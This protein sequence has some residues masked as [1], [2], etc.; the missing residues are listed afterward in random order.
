MNKRTH[1][2]IGYLSRTPYTGD[3]VRDQ[4][5]EDFFDTMKGE[6]HE[7]KF[8]DLVNLVWQFKQVQSR[9]L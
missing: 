6:Y 8:F 7:G 2:I 4:T 5:T 1:S 9:L 3:V